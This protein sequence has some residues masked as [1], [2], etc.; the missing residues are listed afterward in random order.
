ML[1]SQK[2]R[3][4]WLV[5]GDNN[6][7]FFH[8]TTLVRRRK[9]KISMVKINGA[10]QTE[11]EVL[12]EHVFNYSKN[13]FSTNIRTTL[14]PL[15]SSYLQARLTE[16][17]QR[18]LLDVPSFEEIHMVVKSLSPYKA[19]GPDGCQAFF[20]QQFWNIVGVSVYEFVSAS[21]KE[22]E[23]SREVV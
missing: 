15:Q 7:K 1:W 14:H 6:T 22:G 13:L 5:H 20:Y 17:Q 21:F 2:S 8:S 18:M 11:T 10:S 4:K 9:N 3:V 12:K 23:F 19:S 16:D